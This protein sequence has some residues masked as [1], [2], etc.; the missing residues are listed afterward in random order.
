MM[1]GEK[2]REI[3]RETAKMQLEAAHS[4]KTWRAWSCGSGTTRFTASA[5]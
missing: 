4:E 5:R 3:L 1:L 2:D